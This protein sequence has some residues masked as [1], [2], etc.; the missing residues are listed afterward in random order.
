ME[1]QGA[2]QAALSRA[3]GWSVGYILLLSATLKD[4][5]ARSARAAVMD[6]ESYSLAGPFTGVEIVLNMLRNIDGGMKRP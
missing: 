6:A 4:W 1:A 5:S 3:K 2:Y